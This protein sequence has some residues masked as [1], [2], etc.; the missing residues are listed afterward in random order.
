MH[1]GGIHVIKPLLFFFL[2]VN[3]C[4]MGSGGIDCLIQELEEK[5]TFPLLQHLI[6]ML[7]Q[8]Y[9]SLTHFLHPECTAFSLKSSIGSISSNAQLWENNI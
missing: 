7:P 5:A 2:P 6:K 4:I 9:Y 8:K 1:T 3:L